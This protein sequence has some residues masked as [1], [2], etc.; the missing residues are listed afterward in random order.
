M[1]PWTEAEIGLV[2]WGGIFIAFLAGMFVLF[3]LRPVKNPINKITGSI[4]KVWHRSFISTLLVAGLI[5]SLSVSFRDCNG[6]YDFLLKSKKET[7]M[8]GLQQVSSS[9]EYLSWTM[10]FWLILLLV[11]FIIITKRNL[12]IPEKGTGT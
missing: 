4:S 5:G 9:F 6:N 7:V 1:K 3:Y 2:F 11:L 8:K 10:G 12:K